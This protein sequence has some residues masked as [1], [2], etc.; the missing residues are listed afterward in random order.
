MAPRWRQDGLKWPQ[1]G[2]KLTQDGAKVPQ[3]DAKM[4]EI[5][6]KENSVYKTVGIYVGQYDRNPEREF[7]VAAPGQLK[8]ENPSSEDYYY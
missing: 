2:P 4:A 8:T 3:D 7:K 1:D 5:V 6:K